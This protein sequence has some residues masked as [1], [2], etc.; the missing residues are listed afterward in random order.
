MIS[1]PMSRVELQ[2]A[3]GCDAKA[4]R[5]TI[6]DLKTQRKLIERRVLMPDGSRQVRFNLLASQAHLF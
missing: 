2:Q 3:L 4:L 1:K 6:K 5:S